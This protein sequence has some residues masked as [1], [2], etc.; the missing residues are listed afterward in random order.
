MSDVTSMLA[1]H[2]NG[3]P[4]AAARLL[5]LI[6]DEL[7]AQAAAYMREERRGHTLQPTAL[8]HEAYLRLVGQDQMDWRGRT[9][10][11]AMAATTLRRVLVDHA[12][13]RATDKRAG[14]RAR[15]E[16]SSDG[17]IEMDDPHF[18]LDLEEALT[19]LAST[20]ERQ[21]RVF[22]MRYLGGL[23]VGETAA[24]LGVS[25]ETVKLDWRFAR[26]WLNRELFEQDEDNGAQP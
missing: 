21:A 2:V 9:H 15:V 1:D 17:L 24:A 6:Y 11:F 5:P 3:S 18:V 12:R 26:A 7:R 20:S 22:E 8:V 13:A 10:F 14:D 4:E 25:R 23:S 19:N 16:L